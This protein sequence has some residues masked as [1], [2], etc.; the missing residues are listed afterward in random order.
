LT[1]ITATTDVVAALLPADV[2]TSTLD[3]NGT[4]YTLTVSVKPVA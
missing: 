4:P 1:V 2:S 3:V